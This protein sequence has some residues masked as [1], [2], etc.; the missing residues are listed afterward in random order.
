MDELEP[1][2]SGRTA[3]LDRTTAEFRRTFRRPP[4]WAW[5]VPGRIEVF[6]KH[7]DYAGGR[8]LVCAVPRGFAMVA[9]PRTDGLVTARD[10]RWSTIMDVHQGDATREF[11]GWA[12]YIA[13]VTR[14]LALNFPGAPLGTDLVFASDLPRAAGMSS[15]SAL[16]VAVSLA[17][18]RRGELE[19]RPEWTAAIHDRLDLAGYL[20][21]VENGLTFRTLAGL[22]GVGTHGGSEDHT[23]ILNGA[24]DSV[25]AFS[26][27]P[28]RPAGD[29]LMPATWRFVVMTS[30]VEAA[31]AGAAR[32]RYNRASLA[33]RAIVDAWRQDTRNDS[34]LTLSGALSHDSHAE[35]ALRAAIR[36]HP[37]ATFSSDA[38]DQRLSHFIAEDGRVLPALEAFRRGDKDG[39]GALSS[40][41]QADAE[42]LLQNQVPQTS[43]LAAFA[44]ESGAF[45]A[46]SFGAG[47]GGSVWALAE[48]DDAPD[49]LERWRS[50]YLGR[51]P[52]LTNVSGAILR[53]GPAAI[54]IE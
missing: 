36:R 46:S 12:N 37:G 47:F 24:P 49:F 50:R 38:L 20:G 35:V 3:L 34:S 16:V 19:Q 53:P 27:V 8:S 14:R 11:H 30:G 13:V 28:V 42:S 44:R 33:T 2:E 5:W 39:L 51:F 32:D 10:A 25:R 15:S 18:I 29:A 22:S 17:L 4:T 54:E 6:G 43:T 40:A 45:A 48:A 41:S 23:A 31:K 21:A 26:Y 9:A 52:E 7:T 1:P